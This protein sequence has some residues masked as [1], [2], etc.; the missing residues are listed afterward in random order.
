MVYA[1]G[2]YEIYIP[3]AT[4]RNAAEEADAT[5]FSSELYYHYHK[6]QPKVITVTEKIPAQNAELYGFDTGEGI[7]IVTDPRGMAA[8]MEL[9]L[10]S[11][12]V[13]DYQYEGGIILLRTE[14]TTRNEEGDICW[15]NDGPEI[16]FS[17]DRRYE[18]RFILFDAEGTALR[19][20]AIEYNYPADSVGIDTITGSESE[21]KVYNI[22]GMR[23]GNDIDALP[24][25]LYIIDGK[26]V[27][28]K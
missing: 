1:G 20:G 2:N 4:F 27:V 19:Q 17:K 7:T 6:R 21:R 3:E 5:N 15:I 23:L 10:T 11:Y 26:K 22:Q 18:V 24:A 8:R 28:K 25:G 9:E 14:T 13:E 16:E 12:P